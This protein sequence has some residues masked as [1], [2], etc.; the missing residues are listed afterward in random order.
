V[1][2]LHVARHG[3][4]DW[5]LAGRYQGQLESHLTQ[6]GL[7]QADALAEAFSTGDVRCIFSS[8]L[9]RCTQTAQ[10]IAARLRLPVRVDARL[11]E[12]A[13]GAW[14]GR[15]RRDIERYDPEGMHAWRT[16]PQT[17][18]FEGGE[19]L[20][21][22]NTRWREFVDSLSAVDDAVVVTHDV[23]VRLAILSATNR[24]TKDL[25]APRVCNGAYAVLEMVGSGTL[26][27][28]TLVEECH[29]AHLGDL[30]VDPRAQAL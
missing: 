24:M 12:I 15:L 20:A 22:V 7:R 18:G 17:V 26:R 1:A 3:E 9:E 29:D 21:D 6:L 25:W 10:A 23:V 5:N 11:I 16:A 30:L 19:S 13:H 27:Q 4:T 14:E 28:L 2:R 8:P